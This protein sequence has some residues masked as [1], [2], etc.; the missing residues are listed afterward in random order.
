MKKDLTGRK[1]GMLT[2]IRV[3]GRNKHNVLIWECKCD[4]GNISYPTSNSLLSGNTKSC[5]CVTRR[6]SGERFRKMN[7]THQQTYTR[8]YHTWCSMKSRCYRKSNDHYKSY[9]ERGITMCDE[10]RNNFEAFYE[11]AIRNGYS[12]NLTIDRIDNDKGYYPNN[13]QWISFSDNTRKKR[14]TVF[15]TVNNE[16]KSIRE[17]G[18][19]LGVSHSTVRLFY[20][21]YGAL[22]TIEAITKSIQNKDKRFIYVKYYM[23]RDE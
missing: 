4:C 7:V 21:R 3:V 9:G 1:F 10:W 12:D 13:C 16:N 14:N 17:W 2:A 18:N 23:D 22:K 8:L 11:W 15:L 5:G 20:K 19:I 6:K